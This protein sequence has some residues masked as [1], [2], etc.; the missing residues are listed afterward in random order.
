MF[1]SANARSIQLLLQLPPLYASI[2]FELLD[3]TGRRRER[4]AAVGAVLHQVLDVF[5][6]ATFALKSPGP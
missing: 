1:V 4:L 2:L 6:S 5:R 3:G